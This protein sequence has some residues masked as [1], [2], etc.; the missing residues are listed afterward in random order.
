MFLELEGVEVTMI[1]VEYIDEDA[2]EDL[3][4][5]VLTVMDEWMDDETLDAMLEVLD[6][7]EV[8]V[9]VVLWGGAGLPAGEL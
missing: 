3:T 7:V 8:E 6:K 4:V 1:V 9:V 5:E 2:P